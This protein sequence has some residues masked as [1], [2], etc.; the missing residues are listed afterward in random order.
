MKL[1]EWLFGGAKSAEKVLD[2]AVSGI[3]KVFYTDEEKADAREKLGAYWL[4]AQKVLL[5]ESNSAGITRRILA[6]IIMGEFALLVLIAAIAFPFLPEYSQFLVGLIEGQLSL[7][8]LTVG[9]FYYG[10]FFLQRLV[11]VWRGQKAEK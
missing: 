6:W 4:E 11:G 10:P 9:G 1:T 7:L 3:D 5:N 2:G 8:V